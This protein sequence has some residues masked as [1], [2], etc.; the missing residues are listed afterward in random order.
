MLLQRLIR[1]RTS[2]YKHDLSV[3][4]SP[5]VFYFYFC[6]PSQNVHFYY[7]ILTSL[8]RSAGLISPVIAQSR[9]L[10]VDQ[11][12]VFK[13]TKGSVLEVRKNRILCILLSSDL[14]DYVTDQQ[15]IKLNSPGKTDFWQPQREWD[16]TVLRISQQIRFNITH[17]SDSPFCTVMPNLFASGLFQIRL[18]F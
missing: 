6:L 10:S 17:G 12:L 1:L 8:A 11:C 4:R 5:A 9:Q 14:A 3:L 18:S 15:C 13:V 2:R 16:K 7:A